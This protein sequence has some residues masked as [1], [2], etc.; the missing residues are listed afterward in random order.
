MNIGKQG[1]L[2]KKGILLGL[3]TLGLMLFG[4]AGQAK[5]APAPV[6]VQ[7]VQD[8]ASS[9]EDGGAVAAF[10][11]FT[12]ASGQP[13]SHPSLKLNYKITGTASPTDYV[14]NHQPGVINGTINITAGTGNTPVLFGHLTDSDFE[15]DETVIVTI[16]GVSYTGTTPVVLGSR[17]VF[18]DTIINDDAPPY[19][20]QFQSPIIVSAPESIPSLVYLTF[21]DRFGNYTTHEAFDVNY[22][23]T[24]TVDA[25]DFNFNGSSLRTGILH[26]PAGSGPYAFGLGTNQN[27]ETFE[28]D[29]NVVIKITSVGDKDPNT[30]LQ[31]GAPDTFVR[32][33][34]ND[35]FPNYVE[36][37]VQ[38]T[39][40]PENVSSP[41]WFR[42]RDGFFN[43]Y[44]HQ[45]I[46]VNYQI[47]GTADYSQ[48]NF[49]G[50]H[51]VSGVGTLH[52]PAGNGDYLVGSIDSIEDA[53]A[54]SDQ[55]VVIT[56]T[57]VS[58]NDPN[59]D[60]R[61]GP[62]NTLVHIIQ[63]N[64]IAAPCNLSVQ[65]V[66]ATSTIY[67]PDTTVPLGSWNFLAAN[68][69]VTLRKLTLQTMYAN[70]SG[71][72]STLGTFGTLTLWDGTTHLATANYVNG[73]VVFDNF[74][75]VIPQNINKVYTLKGNINNSGVITNNT[76]VN[77]VIK[78]D[79]PADIQAQCSSGAGLG[80][81]DIN[82]YL[83]TNSGSS[84]SQFAPS[85][86]HVFHDA[87]PVIS[88]L[89]FGSSQLPIESYAKIF[90]FSVRNAGTRDLRLGS[91]TV[92]VSSFGLSSAGSISD[93]RLY[94]DN[95]MGGLGIYLAQNNSTIISSTNLVPVV[96]NNSNDVSSLLDN[97]VVAPGAT[98]TFIVTANTTNVLA[99][100][101][102]G[103]TVRVSGS[104]AGLPGWNGTTWST[105]NLL[106]YYTPVNWLEQGPFSASDSYY[107]PGV[108]GPWLSFS[109]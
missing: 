23:I 95:G 93:F 15:P 74:A 20:V 53:V 1:V 89:P 56:I 47:S 88:A 36:F 39:A 91:A 27:D 28:S 16:T 21:T 30:Q 80:S 35:D 77:F 105:G 12:N 57:G 60:L 75:S 38:A 51:P 92:S 65:E 40:S 50:E 6:T 70:G 25:D 29:E 4:L 71:V 104:I 18:T 45:D 82:Y 32:T 97:L 100:L 62:A 85:T 67:G 26:V 96:F 103:S 34:T 86:V 106:Y 99:G 37:A 2:G 42:F 17:K 5:A 55:T 68:Q 109:L 79:S 9:V 54:E 83:S 69:D 7:F 19:Y 13:V 46:Y 31:I 66:A 24:G 41:V 90:K 76:P 108:I 14:F 72:A 94:E 102:S 11:T 8:S 49:L 87:Y 52:I 58:D 22:E 59:T 48:Y 73:N 44:V 61:V 10:F 78:S 33:I 98:R 84:E 107:S 101:A 43:N 64:D 81:A 3:A 63:D